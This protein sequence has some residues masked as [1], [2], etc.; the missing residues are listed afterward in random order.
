MPWYVA[1]P[2][3]K[4][5]QFIHK[6]NDFRFFRLDYRTLHFCRMKVNEPKYGQICMLE[7][8]TWC[9]VLKWGGGLSANAKLSAINAKSK[10]KLHHPADSRELQYEIL[11][12]LFF[13]PYT[14]MRKVYFL[15]CGTV[16]SN[17]ARGIKI[18]IS[19]TDL[20]MSLP[21]S[22]L[23]INQLYFSNIFF[24]EP[25]VFTVTV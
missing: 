5:V 8:V 20:S 9:F 10:M 22:V 6:T 23:V 13:T 7:H 25:T 1:T 2:G 21:N 18:E 14:N 24:E 3:L 12:V 19:L 16:I 11:I 4:L 15:N 17:G